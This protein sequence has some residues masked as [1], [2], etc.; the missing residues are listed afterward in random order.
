MKKFH[1]PSSIKKGGRPLGKVRTNSPTQLSFSTLKKLFLDLS[2]RESLV[3]TIP[4]I[5]DILFYFLQMYKINVRPSINPIINYNNF[6]LA[7]KKINYN[8]FWLKGE[9]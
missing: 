3:D 7:K 2:I 1:S 8:H 6:C 5:Y 4:W 9:H